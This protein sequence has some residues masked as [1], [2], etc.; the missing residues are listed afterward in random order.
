M[1]VLFVNSTQP[2]CGVYQFGKRVYELARMSNRVYYDYIEV[3]SREQFMTALSTSKPDVILY[4][5]YPVTMSWLSEDMVLNNRHQKHFFIFHDGHVRQSFD[6][7]LFSGAE[8]KDINFPLEKTAILPRPLFIY[9]GEYTKNDVPTIGSFG[10]GGWQKG[11]TNLVEL[12]NDQFDAAVINIQMPFAY[13]GDRHG[14]ETRKI[15]NECRKL[16]RNP[17]IQL[18]IDHTFLSN[19]AILKFLAGNDINVFLYRSSNQGLSSV[20]DYALS[21][22]R[23][24]GITQDSMFKHIYKQEICTDF[25]SINNILDRGIQPL[26]EFYDRWNPQNFSVEMDKIYE[27]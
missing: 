4:N 2:V 21:V 5:W 10:F 7:Y 8:G 14:I 18:N 11:F 23:P 27:I 6:K 3:D 20:V 13:F 16:N 22:K 15:A 26:E 1:K 9:D 19:D 25:D 12:V 24:V 17:K